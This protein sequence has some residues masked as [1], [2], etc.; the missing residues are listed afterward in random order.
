MSQYQ[1]LKTLW[2]RK[3]GN[4]RPEKSIIVSNPRQT[5]IISITGAHANTHTIWEKVEKYFDFRF[6]LHSK[7]NEKSSH[8]EENKIYTCTLTYYGWKWFFMFTFINV[9]QFILVNN[10]LISIDIALSK[11]DISNLVY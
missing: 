2:K 9:V 8:P 6:W 7:I 4:I 5:N 3:N 10:I 1:R 11:K